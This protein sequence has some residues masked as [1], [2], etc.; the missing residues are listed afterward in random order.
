MARSGLTPQ[1]MHDSEWSDK[2][3]FFTKVEIASGL[4]PLA[5]TGPWW[6]TKEAIIHV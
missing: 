1:V 2:A 5:M 4:R 3:I 6:I